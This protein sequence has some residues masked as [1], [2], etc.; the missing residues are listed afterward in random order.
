MPNYNGVWSLVTQYQ[1][2]ADWN[3]DNVAPVLPRGLFFGGDVGSYIA[4][5][6]HIQIASTGNATDYGDLSS[7][8]ANILSGMGA[9]TTR[10]LCGG[11]RTDSINPC[12]LIDYFTIA[13]T[14]SGADFGDLTEARA[15]TSGASS[16]T[17][18]LFCCGNSGGTAYDTVDYVTIATLGNATD[19][20]NASATKYGVSSTGS[21]T[22]VIISGGSDYINV[23]EYFTITSTGNATDFGN[24]LNGAQR[25]YACSSKTRSIIAGGTKTSPF[26]YLDV[27]QYVTTAS[28]G[29]ATDFGDMSAGKQKGG[30]CSSSVRGVFGGGTTGSRTNV[31]DYITIASTGN[32]SDFGDL[33]QA[34]DDCAAVSNDHGGL[35]T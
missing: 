26:A 1:Y 35:Q 19:F 25:T 6:D 11:G 20:G 23:M 32:T 22:R 30:S 33:T 18:A 28:T 31:I 13:S 17:R 27:I 14:G 7:E 10:G 24:L 9:S 5:I 8:R 21:S 2:A 34:K 3:A 29:N 16:S 12:N 15:N 4:E